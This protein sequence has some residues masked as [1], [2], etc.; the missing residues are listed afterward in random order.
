TVSASAS[1]SD[2]EA[3]DSTDLTANK[4]HSAA[5][6]TSEQQATEQHTESGDTN[7]A[8]EPSSSAE[9]MD[10]TAKDGTVASEQATEGVA[11]PIA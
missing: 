4:A 11:A 6:Q 8:G 1:T 2:A 7:P 10:A 5:Q 3:Q 9:Q